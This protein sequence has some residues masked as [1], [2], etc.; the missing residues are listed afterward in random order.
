M[1]I[2]AGHQ[3]PVAQRE[4]TVSRRKNKA[5]KMH[6]NAAHMSTYVPII[7]L[8]AAAVGWVLMFWEKHKNAGLRRKLEELEATYTSR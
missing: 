3:L 1:D 5:P 7:A 2:A 6:A 8:T 4:K